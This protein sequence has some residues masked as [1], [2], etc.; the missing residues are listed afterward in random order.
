MHRVFDD[1]LDPHGRRQVDDDIR[2]AGQPVEH[3]GVQDG[4]AQLE[5]VCLLP[6]GGRCSIFSTRPVDRSS[7]A[8]TV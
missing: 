6:G 7:M 2:L 5:W 8:T 1:Q 4:L 3:L